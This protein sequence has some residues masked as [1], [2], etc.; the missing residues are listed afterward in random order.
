MRIGILAGEYPPMQGGVGAYTHILARHLADL[1]HEIFVLSHLSATESDDRIR[2]FPHMPDWSLGSLGRLRRWASEHKLDI[3]HLQ[4]QTAAFGMSP[5]IHFYPDLLKGIPFVT[6]FHDLRFPYLFPKAGPLR[7]WIVRHLAAK[8][9]AV[10][11]TNH[12]DAYAL[13]DHPCMELIPIGSNI[14]PHNEK[15]SSSPSA[16]LSIGYFGFINHSKGVDLLLHALALG[17]DRGEDWRLTMIGG[18]TGSSDPTN[19]TYLLEIESLIEQLN[20]ADHLTWTGFIE[21]D[22]VADHLQQADVVALPFHDGASFRRGSLVAAIQH[23]CAIVTTRPA[24]PIPVFL[25][26]ENMLFCERSPE[27]LYTALKRVESDQALKQRLKQGAVTL[28]PAFDWRTIARRTA[29]VY[30]RILA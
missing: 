7:P 27:S 13:E 1:D 19:A 6:T 10:I 16:G 25:D 9:R 8:S 4:Y 11:V 20:L 22:A 30:E 26:G 2:I 29:A 3:V 28:A 24:V 23:G 17:R 5:F 12:E 18:Q 15:P 21:D 14:P